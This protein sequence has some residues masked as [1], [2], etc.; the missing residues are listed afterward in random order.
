MCREMTDQQVAKEQRQNIGLNLAANSAE[1]TAHVTASWREATVA[2]KMTKGETLLADLR[3]CYK[4]ITRAKNSNRGHNKVTFW[5][6]F[7]TF[8]KTNYMSKTLLQT[9]FTKRKSNVF[10]IL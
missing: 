3:Q 5:K 4:T 7:F 2:H 8:Y 10:H 9:Q 6:T 1:I